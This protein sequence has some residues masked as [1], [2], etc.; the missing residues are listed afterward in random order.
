MLSRLQVGRRVVR[1][2]GHPFNEWHVGT[3]VEVNRR[4][5][6]SENVTAR[7]V[8]PEEGETHGMFVADADTYGVVGLGWTASG[9]RSD[10]SR[11]RAR[12]IARPSARG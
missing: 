8:S 5:R 7:F 9:W 11:F 1:W 6:L 10:L 4:R 3:V 2:F 12:G